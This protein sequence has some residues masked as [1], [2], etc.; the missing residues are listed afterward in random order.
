[1]LTSPELI[2]L[3]GTFR[4]PQIGVVKKGSSHISVSPQL[5]HLS[6]VSDL[7]R[8]QFPTS[9]IQNFYDITF[10]NGASV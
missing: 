2:Y 3:Q 10:K 4:S 1:M 6:V 8:L 7:Y 5:Y 9:W